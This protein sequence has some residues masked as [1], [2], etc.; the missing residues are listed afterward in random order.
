VRAAGDE[1]TRERKGKTSIMLVL[2]TPGAVGEVEGSTKKGKGDMRISVRYVIRRQRQKSSEAGE[3][4][5][6]RSE[7]GE[8]GEE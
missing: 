3:S 6:G 1:G 2:L 7:R 5:P 4:H 8:A